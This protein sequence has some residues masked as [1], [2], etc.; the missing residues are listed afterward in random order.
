MDRARHDEIGTSAGS[1]R[2]EASLIELRR[3]GFP[4]PLGRI[5]HANGMDIEAELTDPRGTE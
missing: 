4:I 2:R 3:G 1:R 5:E